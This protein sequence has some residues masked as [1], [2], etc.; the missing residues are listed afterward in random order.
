VHL[1]H[2]LSGLP[3]WATALLLLVA[4]TCLAA[5]APFLIRRTVGF[6]RLVVN[7]E[8][9]GFQ[10]S[11]LGTSYA[12]LL[13]LAVVAVWD[14]FRDAQRLVDGEASAWINLHH[15]AAAMPEPNRTAARGALHA[16]ALALINEEWPAMARG[17]ESAA[18]TRAMDEVRGALLTMPVADARGAVLYDHLLDRVVELSEG[19]RSRL[20]MVRGS[21]PP[22][23]DMVLVAGAA[24]TVAFTL[25]FAGRDVRLQGVMT[26]LLCLMIMLVLFAAIELNYPFSG[27]VHVVPEPIEQVLRR[28]AGG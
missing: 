2:A 17:R 9:A 21:L 7:N 23:I 28:A 19:R 11:T 24:I 25:F 20:D 1:F 6:E 8:V 18:A 14:D 16:Y 4:S 26:G 3:L 27:G 15:L 12:V 22:L 10:Y 13:A 5:L